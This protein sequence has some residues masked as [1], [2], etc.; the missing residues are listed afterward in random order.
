[1]D[2]KTSCGYP[3]ANQGYTKT[4]LINEVV[5]PGPVRASITERL[6]MAM[7]LE[8]K[9]T[10]FT[11]CLKDEKRPLAK[12]F[13]PKTRSF[14]MCPV[15][16]NVACRMMMMDFCNWFVINGEHLGHDMG[17]N[18]ESPDWTKLH[19]KAQTWLKTKVGKKKKRLFT[20]DVGTFDGTIR[21]FFMACFFTLACKWYDKYAGP[22]PGHNKVRQVFAET[23]MHRMIR[24]LDALVMEHC[25]NP[26]GFFATTIF[27]C[28]VLMCYLF[29]YAK[30]YDLP[31][32]QA[33]K[34]LREEVN[35]TMF[36]DDSLLAAIEEFLY[37]WVGFMADQGI[38]ITD[39]AKDGPPV[40]KSFA[41]AMYLSR[42][43]RQSQEFGDGMEWV[44]TLKLSSIIALL[45]WT[46]GN[47]DQEVEDLKTALRM[48]VFHGP[49]VYEHYV[50][51]MRVRLRSTGSPESDLFA[52]FMLPYGKMVQQVR[53]MIARGEVIAPY[54]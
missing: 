1:M 23:L 8:I 29:W 7:K 27:N 46:R 40:P 17:I 28:F 38:V 42:G 54:E 19:N 21:S 53:E 14:T 9:P 12:I 39:D 3:W 30:K 43:F 36:G 10:F 24:V 49:I 47:V 20:S 16:L 26:S 37:G 45:T 31:P 41:T 34:K 18:P 50:D 11:E 33:M 22:S 52:S 15:D 32:K 51:I 4:D 44:P 5:T 48:L 13:N 6:N 35:W 25:G 2:T